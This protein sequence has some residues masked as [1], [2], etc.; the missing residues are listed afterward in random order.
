MIIWH[1]NGPSPGKTWRA[2][3]LIDL[4]FF[5]QRESAEKTGVKEDAAAAENRRIYL[6][7]SR[8][9][10]PPHSRRDLLK[11]WLEQKRKK[12]T[13]GAV[14]GTG[15]LPGGMFDEILSLA[16]LAI[17][18]TAL[19]AGM[20][21]AWSVLSYRG[22]AP[23]NIFTCL[24]LF[25]FPQFLMLILLGGMSV[26]RRFGLSSG[27]WGV[28]PL[29]AF[30]LRRA[31]QS[32]KSA[33][34]HRLSAERKL[35]IN[36]AFGMIGR[37]KTIYGSVF[38]RPV[39]TLFQMF[40][41]CFNIGLLGAAL[42]KITI[43]D[44]A[45]GWQ[46]TLTAGAAGVYRVVGWISLPWSWLSPFFP[47]HP[48]LSQIQGSR[49][50][51]KDGLAHLA[52]PD[53]VSWW[54]FLVL[55]IIVYG[56]LPRVLLLAWGITAQA[57]GLKALDFSHSAC[58]RLIRRMQVPLV[59][60]GGMKPLEPGMP[61]GRKPTLS[62][63]SDVSAS[64]GA[65]DVII[66]VPEENDALRADGELTERIGHLLGPIISHRFRLT[67]DPQT[68]ALVL[69]RL[70]ED[71]NPQRSDFRVLLLQEAWLPPIRE[72]LSWIKAIR[73]TAGPRTGMIIG[74]VGKPVREN[75]LT[76]PADADRLIW[77]QAVS[78]LADPYIRVE[79]LGG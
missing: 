32:L 75:P 34:E 23:I 14:G 5:L 69:Q 11:F 66:G 59:E 27:K 13:A 36:S 1:E 18:I 16:R 31:A 9:H 72:T 21:L 53:L 58:D 68:D 6:E 51:L 38:Y 8:S 71:L 67:M 39:F 43:T 79:T 12:E 37:H 70:L 76:S 19:L 22:D 7:F 3:D 30:L 25:I 46:T 73:R 4:E 26:F 63:S 28:Y 74:L 65:I 35:R 78:G 20:A 10:T 17:I 60:T 77:Q 57:R 64:T 44:L 61:H 52:T 2:S 41:V 50:I 33:G 15:P 24:W 48:T 40:G 42:F 56:L 49:I 54:P 55:A 45:F 29:L 47:A 62:D